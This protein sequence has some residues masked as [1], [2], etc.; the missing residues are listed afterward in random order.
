MAG[1]R[2]RVLWPIASEGLGAVFVAYD[3]KRDRDMASKEN[4]TPHA[5]DPACRGRF[6]LGPNG[7]SNLS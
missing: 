1:S 7:N 6:L 3:K 5:D 2:F 4:R